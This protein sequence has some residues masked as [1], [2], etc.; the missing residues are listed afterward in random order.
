MVKVEN[1]KVDGLD[2]AIRAMRHPME[3]YDKSDSYYDTE[4]GLVIGKND[5]DLM[6]RLYKSGVEHRTFGRVVQVWMDIS[7]PLY[8]WKEFDRYTVGKSQVSTS[9]MHKIH[10]KQFVWDDFSHEHLRGHSLVTLKSIID[11]L[12]F[13]REMYVETKDKMY[14]LQ[15]IQLLPSSYN[16]KRT[17]NMSYEVV[18]KIIKERKN[19][20]LDEWKNFVAILEDLP[21]VKEIMYGTE[22]K[23]I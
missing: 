19:H 12:N 11:E 5:L 1:I 8:T 4:R 20:K 7:L 15:M 6:H 10:A 16:Q 21:Y 23:K 18:F 3:S 14:W 9:T 13:N 17:I 2:V 22:S